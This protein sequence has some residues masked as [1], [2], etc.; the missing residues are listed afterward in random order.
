MQVVICQTLLQLFE[1]LPNN[2]IH[3]MLN[4]DKES[5]DDFLRR[6]H[7]L[8]YKCSTKN[9]LAVLILKFYRCSISKNV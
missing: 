6:Y 2:L 8:R 3:F 5:I 1:D 4:T 7:M 9:G